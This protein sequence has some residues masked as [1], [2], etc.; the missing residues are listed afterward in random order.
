MEDN[1]FKAPEA[2]LLT[3]DND[4]GTE[5]ASRWS[6]LWG[7]LIDGLVML[8]VLVPIMFITGY[9][10]YIMEGTEPS[11]I[12]TFAMLFASIIIFFAINYKLLRDNGQTI[13]KKAVGTKIVGINDE[14][15]QINDHILKRYL[16]YFIPGQIPIIG[17]IFSLIN[18]LF[19]FGAEKRCIHD[20]AGK[21]K[22]VKC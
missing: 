17:S 18:L 6:R 22:V 5:L 1:N 16:T 7:S 9:T 19:I 8:V 13:G 10:A 4:S 3:E 21:T 15:A 2:E 14:K 11:F 12:F 20:L